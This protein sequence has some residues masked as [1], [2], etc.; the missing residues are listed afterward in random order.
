MAKKKG[1][2]PHPTNI[3]DYPSAMS[4][5]ERDSLA[6]EAKLAAERK[7]NKRPKSAIKSK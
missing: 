5:Y 1:G 7:I 4:T 6:A 2:Q 3:L